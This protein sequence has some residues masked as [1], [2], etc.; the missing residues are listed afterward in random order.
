MTFEK[1]ENPY[2]EEFDRIAV[3]DA[4]RTFR[5]KANQKQ[6][7][8]MLACSIHA[9]SCIGS[10]N[11]YAWAHKLGSCSLHGGSLVWR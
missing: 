9:A 4:I 8:G 5:G 7:I 1:Q 10:Q 2:D 3:K 6:M 11:S